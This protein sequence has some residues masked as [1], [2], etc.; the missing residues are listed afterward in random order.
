VDWKQASGRGSIHSF[1]VVHR[2]DASYVIAYVTLEEGVTVFTNIVD[3]DAAA[4]AIGAPVE[5]VFE[6]S[7]TGQKV[8]VF[9]VL[10][11]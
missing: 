6:P 5:V 8:P 3:S 1:S 9:R 10:A 2:K 11:G 7:R 4:V